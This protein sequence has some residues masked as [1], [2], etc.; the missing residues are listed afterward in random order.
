MGGEGWDEAYSVQETTDGGFIIAGYS[1]SN[2]DDVSGNHGSYDYW[3]VKLTSDT[4][5]GI[6][7]PANN[8]ISLFPNPVQT[9]L[10]ITLTT[11][12]NPALGET[13]HVYDLQGRMIQVPITFTNTQAQLNTTSLPDG[14]YTL[15]ITNNKTGENAVG[16]FVKQ[17]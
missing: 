3:I 9:E 8:F 10:F 13:I 4:V 17:Q 2:N 7:S 12:A 5:S 6:E 1:G 14:F 15:Q 11:P 16:K